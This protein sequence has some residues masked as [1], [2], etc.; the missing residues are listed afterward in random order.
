MTRDCSMFSC[1]QYNKFNYLYANVNRPAGSS[2]TPWGVDDQINPSSLS[3][4]HKESILPPT[5]LAHPDTG[6]LG[7][8][9]NSRVPNR[10]YPHTIPSITTPSNSTVKGNYT[11]VSQEVQELLIKGAIV[12]ITPSSAGFISQIFLVEKKGGGYRPVI[13][14]KCLNQ[15]VRVEHFEMEGATPPPTPHPARGLDDEAGSE[16]CILPDPNSPGPS[17]PPPIYLGGETLQVPRSP[18]GL[19]AV[20][21][22]FTKLLKPVVVFLRQIGLRIIIYLDDMLFMH[23]SKEQLAAMAPSICRLFE[24]LGLMVN[25]KKSS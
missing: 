9:G 23:A 17:T 24:A 10:P 21:R 15:F 1:T 20:P 6:Q 2:S 5:E 3:A 4:S 16:G 18:F 8:S 25:M 14:F 12:E 13:N 11:M 19:S 22:V 7:P